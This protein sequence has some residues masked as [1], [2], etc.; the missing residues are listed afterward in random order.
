[1][2]IRLLSKWFL[3][4][5]RGGSSVRVL[6]TLGVGE[7]WQLHLIATEMADKFHIVCQHRLIS[8]DFLGLLSWEFWQVLI[9]R[10]PLVWSA[11]DQGKGC[12]SIYYFWIIEDKL[13]KEHRFLMWKWKRTIFQ[14]E[15]ILEA[16]RVWKNS[17]AQGTV[18]VI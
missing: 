3:M 14:V 8:E 2:E 15:W 18:W 11:V 10:S 5:G 7:K 4:E 17:Y 9:Q 1:M 13:F 6:R 12:G 16:S